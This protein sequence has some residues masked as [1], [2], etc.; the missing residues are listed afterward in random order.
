MLEEVGIKVENEIIY[1][2]SNAFVADDGDPVIDIVFL[3]RYKSGKLAV[4]DSDE[5]TAVQWMT[6]PDI[7]AHPKTPAWT[8]QSIELAESLR[9]KRAW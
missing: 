3:C 2:E 4:V 1:V 5:V 6:V 7:L 8:R 9:V